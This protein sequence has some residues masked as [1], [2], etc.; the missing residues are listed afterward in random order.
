MKTLRSTYHDALSAA[1]SMVRVV[2]STDSRLDY[3]MPLDTAIAMYGKLSWD[4]ASKAYRPISASPV[5]V[6]APQH[7]HIVPN[8]W[9]QTFDAYELAALH[10]HTV[11]IAGELIESMVR[12]HT[13]AS[14]A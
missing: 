12:Q 14:H 10:T 11:A 3:L 7:T 2:P 1:M 13:G 9:T 4:A 5:A 8:E 6:N